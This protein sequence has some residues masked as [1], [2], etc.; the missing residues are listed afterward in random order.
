[1]LLLQIDRDAHKYF[2]PITRLGAWSTTD[3]HDEAKS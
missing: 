1:M 2:S 3:L